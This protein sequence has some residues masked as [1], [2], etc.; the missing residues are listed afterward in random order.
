M[1]RFYNR[2]A[3]MKEHKGESRKFVILK[4]CTFITFCKERLLEC[5][6]SLVGFAKGWF[7]LIVRLSA[8]NCNATALV[9]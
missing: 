7:F 3:S 6:N 4:G 2:F 1:D 9:N 8:K 5:V